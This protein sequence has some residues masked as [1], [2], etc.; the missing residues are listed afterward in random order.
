MVHSLEALLSAIII[1]STLIYA[2]SIP[3]DRD[4]ANLNNLDNLGLN[5]LLKLDADGALGDMVEGREWDG[6][7]MC[8]RVVIPT[9]VSFNL[10]VIGEDGSYI[11]DRPI[12]NG[13]LIGRSIT[14]V[15]YLLAIESDGCPLY[16]IRL[17]L[18]R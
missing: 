2:S 4:Q 3:R 11:N 14:S 18:G 9:G 7:E 5:A 15:D 1:F 17:Q 6:L 8:L 16:R 12:S 13:G 10:T